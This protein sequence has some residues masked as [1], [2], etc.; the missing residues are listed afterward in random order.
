MTPLRKKMLE[1]LRL[2]N[3][4]VN[5]QRTY[6]YQVSRFARHFGACP[7]TLGADEVRRWMLHLQ[8]SGRSAATR[9]TARSALRFLYDETLHR[10][11]VME[12]IPRP[13]VRR[14]VV[15]PLLRSEGSRL[16]EASTTDVLD[17][18][19]VLTMLGTGLRN[20]ELRHLRVG[21]IDRPAGLV[22]VR[23]GKG[24][25]ARCV[26]LDDRLY[27]VLRRYWRT[28]RPPGP[29][30]FPAQRPGIARDTP[31]NQRWADKPMGPDSLRRRL[32]RT[33]NRAGIQ[34]R[35][36]PHDLRRTYATWMVE[37]AVPLH[38]VQALL[39]HSN[40]DTTV[41]Y[42]R[43]RPEQIQQTPTPLSML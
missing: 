2:R 22:H 1:E 11:E 5:T 18:A 3:L 30:V 21:D 15:N 20:A 32:H 34:R 23:H 27:D 13:R 9:A 26:R 10:P 12:K 40:A 4:A 39:G 29:W 35:V 42:T 38:I 6:V 16:V 28:C 17:E 36:T 25:K 19:L 8:A 33:A 41:R 14:A 7:S 24:D 31:R 37:A 43:V